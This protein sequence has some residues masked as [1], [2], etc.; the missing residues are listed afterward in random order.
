MHESTRAI[1]YVAIT[2]LAVLALLLFAVLPTL[3][4][5]SAPV[6]QGF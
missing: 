4:L 1:T 5:V 2:V 6:Y 3:S